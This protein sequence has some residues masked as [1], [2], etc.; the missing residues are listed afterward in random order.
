MH[1]S[2]STRTLSARAHA[3][4][5]GAGSRLFGRGIDQR[6][7]AAGHR[8]ALGR[9]IAPALDVVD[10]VVGVE[11]VAVRPSH[12]WAHMQRVFGAV[13]TDV[14]ALDQMAL[15]SKVSGVA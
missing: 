5:D 7:H 15:E 9:F 6:S 2:A 1:S 10:D 14:P 12:A 11:L 3:G 8:V 4:R 13:V